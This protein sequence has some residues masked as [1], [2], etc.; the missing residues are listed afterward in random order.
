M[1][2]FYAAGY[3]DSTK[4]NTLKSLRA[5]SLRLIKEMQKESPCLSMQYELGSFARFCKGV[6]A[7][8][9][10]ANLLQDMKDVDTLV[11]EPLNLFMLRDDGRILDVN[12]TIAL[13]AD[14]LKVRIV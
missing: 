9:A 8:N 3:S 11:G 10:I 12:F 4:E 7:N 13:A 1:S 5:N 6:W 14:K 2:K